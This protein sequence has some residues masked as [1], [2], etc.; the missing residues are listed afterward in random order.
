MPV[1]L[2][3]TESGSVSGG[4]DINAVCMNI[5]A[6]RLLHI[7]KVLLNG[8]EDCMLARMDT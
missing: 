4:D 3:L 5:Y 6:L 2:R 7:L 8:Y 1:M